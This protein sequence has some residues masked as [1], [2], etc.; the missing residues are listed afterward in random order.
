MA[1]KKAAGAR[2]PR[3]GGRREKTGEGANARTL[4]LLA[5]HGLIEVRQKRE[6]LSIVSKLFC[7]GCTFNEIRESVLEDYPKDYGD[8]LRG[9]NLWDLLRTAAREN[10][11]RHTPSDDVELTR[12][13][14]DD[15][16][17]LDQHVFVA[18]TA[19][20]GAL[21]EEAAT[22]L[23]DMIRNVRKY[24]KCDTVHVGF[25]GGMTLRAVAEK[26]ALLLRQPH[27][28]NPGTLVFHAMVASFDD[29]DFYADP[30]S[31]ITYFIGPKCRVDVRLVR[32]PLPGI[33]EPAG[34]EKARQLFGIDSVFERRSEIHIVVTSGSLWS[35]KHS[36]LR[37]YLTAAMNEEKRKHEGG[38]AEDTSHGKTELEL[39]LDSQGVVGDLLWQ[40]INEEG[41]V[42]FPSGYRVTTLMEL[43][44]LPQ[45]IDDGGSVLLVMGCSGISRKPKSDLLRAILDL[46]PDHNWIT[47]VVTDSP[48][49]EGMYLPEIRNSLPGKGAT[50]KPR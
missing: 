38:Q 26:L 12:K 11:F 36:T 32:L 4:K 6:F 22:R 37:T 45:F 50:R 5:D 42:G 33:I 21:A 2:R 3:A 29:D 27:P 43:D 48:T 15:Y 47:D 1:K 20:T 25:A 9:E 35:D 17:W 18:Q 44:E 41:P 39:E 28:D 7:E 10:L 13:L 8:L 31:F 19:S 46:H 24:Q 40:P 30:N 16:H 23:L 49:V 14:Q 34:Y